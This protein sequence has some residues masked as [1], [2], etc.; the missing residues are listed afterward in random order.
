MITISIKPFLVPLEALSNRQT[1][2]SLRFQGK[3]DGVKGLSTDCHH[4]RPYPY[5]CS[6]DTYQASIHEFISSFIDGPTARVSSQREKIPRREREVK[7]KSSSG[8]KE[9]KKK[10]SSVP[11]S[12]QAFFALGHNVFS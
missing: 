6:F 7:S 2:R 12:T 3:L 5:L 8:K 11:C 1:E 10:L 4:T 9:P